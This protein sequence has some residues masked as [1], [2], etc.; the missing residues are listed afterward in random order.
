V[1]LVLVDLHITNLESLTS[2]FSFLSKL[3]LVTFYQTYPVSAQPV[4]ALNVMKEEQ[5]PTYAAPPSEVC[6]LP[7]TPPPT[8]EP[9][10][11]PTVKAE[12]TR[13]TDG[14]P[15]VYLPSSNGFQ[16]SPD[17]PVPAPHAP[18]GSSPTDGSSSS[19]ILVYKQWTVQTAAVATI[20]GA[21]VLAL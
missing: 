3:I 12:S 11:P 16:P 7:P 17:G 20:G 6:G 9:T 15:T 5:L 19:A 1:H 13:Y 14:Q 2:S 8:P 10:K 18:L 4:R 21:L